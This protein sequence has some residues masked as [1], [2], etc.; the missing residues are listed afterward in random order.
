MASASDTLPHIGRRAARAERWAAL[1]AHGHTVWLTGLPGS[2]KTTIAGALERRL[3]D[4]GRPACVLDGDELRAGLTSDLGFSREARAENARRV[5]EVACILADAG[6][7]AIVALVSPYAADRDAARVLHARAG[8]GFSEIYVSTPLAV[9]VERDP[10]GLYAR[11]AGGRLQG[12]TG[13]DAPYEPPLT[14]ELIVTTSGEALASI[15]DRI[16]STLPEV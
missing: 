5:G 12:L 14:P 15:V 4:R 10:K 8:L 16:A 2:G 1:R 13:S 3:L 7:V 11:A 6:S 9:C